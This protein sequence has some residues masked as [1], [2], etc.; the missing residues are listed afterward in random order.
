M[1][2]PKPLLQQL[3]GVKAGVGGGRSGRPSWIQRAGGVQPQLQAPPRRQE[4]ELSQWHPHPQRW[5][6][7][8]AQQQL[9]AGLLGVLQVMGFSLGWDGWGR[10]V[11]EAPREPS[12]HPP[13]EWRVKGVLVRFP[14]GFGGSMPCPQVPARR[15]PRLVPCGQGWGA[16]GRLIVGRLGGGQPLQPPRHLHTLQHQADDHRHEGL[17]RRGQVG[18]LQ[19]VD[20]PQP[21]HLA[22]S[23]RERAS[24]NAPSAPPPQQHERTHHRQTSRWSPSA[25]M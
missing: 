12:I 24:G 4:Q 13:P 20:I 16:A 1:L 7:L 6:S 2:R 22:S 19:G 15:A 17:H 14:A 18:G 3:L 23:A 21:R 10:I 25:R 11:S 8:G 5:A 9:S